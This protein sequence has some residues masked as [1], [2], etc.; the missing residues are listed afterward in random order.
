MDRVA[1]EK[2]ET[3]YVIFPCFKC[4]H[5]LSVKINQKTKKCLRCGRTHQV[6]SVVNKGEIVY[7]VSKAV[8]R[9]KELQNTRGTPKFSAES[10][11]NISSTNIDI[12]VRKEVHHIFNNLLKALS[13]KH[14]E[15][16]LYMIELIAQEYQIP[17]LE[18]KSLIRKAIQEKVLVPL[19]KQRYKFRMN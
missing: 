14:K 18:L 8:I 6:K 7:G 10:G 3:A 11:F 19:S 1:W 16:P 12:E 15:F 5:Y 17:P 2:D 13:L 9:V 4:K